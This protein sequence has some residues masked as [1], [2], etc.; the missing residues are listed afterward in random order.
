MFVRAAQPPA[1]IR[2]EGC[3]RQRRLLV[4]VGY[5]IKTASIGVPFEA[6]TAD[7]DLIAVLNQHPLPRPRSAAP[8]TK[9]SHEWPG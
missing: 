1:E 4:W 3:Q 9:R 6:G 8:S 2:I 7:R 5:H